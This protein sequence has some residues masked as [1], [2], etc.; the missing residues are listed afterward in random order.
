MTYADSTISL[1]HE[2]REY[3]AEYTVESGVVSVTL[4]DYEGMN[5]G[6]S[7]YADDSSVDTV[8]RSLLRDLLRDIGQ[9]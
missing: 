5:R 1:E 6:V 3:R 8:A 2:G 9:I 4:K 7:T